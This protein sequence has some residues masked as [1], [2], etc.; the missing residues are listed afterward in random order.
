MIKS[1]MPARKRKPTIKLAVISVGALF[2]ADLN[3]MFGSIFFFS[4][5]FLTISVKVPMRIG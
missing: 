3:A 2:R 1:K 4:R 5:I